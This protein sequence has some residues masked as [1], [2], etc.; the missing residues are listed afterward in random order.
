MRRDRAGVQQQRALAARALPI[1]CA[2]LALLPG[3]SA[4]QSSGASSVAEP[5]SARLLAPRP[6]CLASLTQFAARA[7]GKP[8]PALGPTAFA[9]SDTLWLEAGQNRDGQ[10][11]LMD[12]A[13]LG[14]PEALHLVREATGRCIVTHPSSGQQAHLSACACAPLPS[15]S[16]R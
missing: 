15:P 8:V 1:L 11:R 10:G 16:P 7:T 3:I 4:C 6:E 13:S 12:G 14:R 5:S 9:Q 2:G